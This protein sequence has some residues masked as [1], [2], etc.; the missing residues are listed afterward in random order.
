MAAPLVGKPKSNKQLLSPLVGS[1][2]EPVMNAVGSESGL[3][4]EHRRLRDENAR[5]SERI[6]KLEELI[7][8]FLLQSGWIGGGGM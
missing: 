5:L 7:R 4:A 1:A 3:E 6:R 2:K 8:L